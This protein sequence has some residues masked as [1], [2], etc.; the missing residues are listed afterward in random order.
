MHLVSLDGPGW[1]R[2]VAGAYVDGVIGQSA[3]RTASPHR[4]R[5]AA[6]SRQLD[7]EAQGLQAVDA[8]DKGLVAQPRQL[9]LAAP[10]TASRAWI[11]LGALMA[12]LRVSCYPSVLMASKR[13]V[14]MAFFIW[15][16]LFR[17]T[18]PAVAGGWRP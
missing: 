1:R 17:G 2:E 14:T 6:R 3:D 8:V 9:H 11:R 7:G 5:R 12:I 4:R 10:V 18:A 15:R 13:A 16:F